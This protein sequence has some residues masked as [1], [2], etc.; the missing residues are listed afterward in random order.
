[1]VWES[2]IYLTLLADL[3][4]ELFELLLTAKKE[5]G[6]ISGELNNTSVP[7]ERTTGPSDPGPV[8]FPCQSTSDIGLATL[9]F[10]ANN[11]VPSVFSEARPSIRRV[12]ATKKRSPEVCECDDP[13]H[14]PVGRKRKQ[15]DGL[16]DLSSPAQRKKRVDNSGTASTRAEKP[17]AH[18]MVAGVCGQCQ[19]LKNAPRGKKIAW[20]NHSKTWMIVDARAHD[21]ESPTE[22]IIEGQPMSDEDSATSP[23]H[24]NDDGG[25][26]SSGPDVNTINASNVSFLGNSETS[27]EPTAKSIHERSTVPSP[28]TDIGDPVSENHTSP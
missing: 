18:E 1:M 26:H 5:S 11:E 25:N 12:V 22:E 20:R 21:E 16:D 3:F 7:Q 19:H 13:D 27:S 9:S 28:T 14:Q 24:A 2:Q 23:T 10:S 6:P 4:S 17:L 8:V 15:K